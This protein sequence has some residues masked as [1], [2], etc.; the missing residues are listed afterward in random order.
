MIEINA[1]DILNQRKLNY[2]PPQFAK[3]KVGDTEWQVNDIEKWIQNTLKGRFYLCKY[4]GIQ[5]DG[6]MKTSVIVGFED[7]KELTYFM[8]A[9]PHLRR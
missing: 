2:V 5:N 4:P 3:T 7:H 6:K 9:C 8:L 1:L